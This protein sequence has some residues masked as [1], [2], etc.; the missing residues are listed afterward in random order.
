[1]AEPDMRHLDRCRHPGDQHDLVRP[2]ELIG[3]AR[4]KAQRHVGFRRRR[5]AL[6][7]PLLRVTPYRVVAA[8]IASGVQLLIHPDQRQPLTRRPVLVCQQ[9]A[10]QLT[11]PRIDP[12][13][14]LSSTLVAELGRFR[15]DYLAHNLPRQP[16]LAA[17]RLDRLPLSKIRPPYLRDRLHYQHPEPGSHV[18]MEAT[19]NPCYR[20]PFGCR[21]PRKRGSY[22]I[23][24]H[25]PSP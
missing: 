11:A 13:Q 19:V 10:V 1:M 21:S 22:S 15:P 5:T 2:V 17:D 25:R 3:L 16:I 23:P 14:G 20:G 6:G 12:R 9:Q 4:R 7:P 8:L 24:I 18:P